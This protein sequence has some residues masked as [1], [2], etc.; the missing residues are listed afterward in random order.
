MYMDVAREQ[1][2]PMRIWVVA[3]LG[4]F[5]AYPAMTTA[6]MMGHHRLG[7]A[8]PRVSSNYRGANVMVMR[9]GSM[10]DSFR[11]GDR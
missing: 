2:G 9:D 10:V 3:V 1:M 8:M 5:V 4:M 11:V 6:F 7:H